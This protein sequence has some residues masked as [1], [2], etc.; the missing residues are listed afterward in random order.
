MKNY[1][2][3]Y[4][5]EELREIALTS[6]IKSYKSVIILIFTFVFLIV[7][8]SSVVK[9]P[10][11]IMGR[12][13]I[14]SK[15]QI[16]NV[17]SPNNG[18]I[19]I[20]INE[21]TN[22][23]KGDLLA[24]INS[25]TDY[26]DLN[27]L[28]NQL[29]N[30]DINDFETSVHNIK[31]ENDFKLGEIERYYNNFLLALIECNN[32]FKIDV[33]SQKIANLKSKISRN[34]EAIKVGELAKNVF[35]K[36]NEIIKNSYE[37]DSTLFIANAI[38]ENT[39]D[40]SKL[41]VL[42]S[43][44]RELVLFINS[45]KLIHSNEE[46]NGEIQLLEK[47]REKAEASVLFNFKKTFYELKTSIDLWEHNHAIKA[48]ISGYL[49]FYQPFLSSTQYVKKD[50]PL[51]ILLPKVDSLYARGI[52][53]ANGY[54]KIKILDTVIIKLKDYPFKE[55]GELKGVIT[56]KSKVYHDSIYIMDISLP[57]GLK[58]NYEK[59]INFSYNMSGDVEYLTKKR[60]ILQRIFNDIQNSID[61]N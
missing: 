1:T 31:F 36:K 17:Y 41:N 34:V 60:S 45:Q 8:I 43:R 30:I 33:S 35:D 49:E 54:G 37:L 23:N 38:V 13:F 48:P 10:E 39:M 57:N 50:S 3:R 18:E 46:L 21:N 42:E 2:D 4:E 52:M 59:H 27:N 20:L 28:K 22:I 40:K 58:T 61:T 55:Y 29:S 9:Y 16:N 5:S 11:K 56:N 24:L 15:K 7:T 47:E 32:T 12:V 51:F 26:N 6:N 14:S 53:S 19:N 44:E 25:P